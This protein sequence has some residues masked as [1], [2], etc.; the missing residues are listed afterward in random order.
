VYASSCTRECVLDDAYD[1]LCVYST[2]EADEVSGL[3]ERPSIT[4]ELHEGRSGIR[5]TTPSFDSVVFTFR[6]SD[7]TRRVVNFTHQ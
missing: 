3:C 1:R 4:N 6:I 7:N 2:R 5:R